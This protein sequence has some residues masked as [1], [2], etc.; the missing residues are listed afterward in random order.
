MLF[1]SDKAG[2]KGIERLKQEI[3]NDTELS[4]R[5]KLIYP[6]PPKLGK[7]YNE[8]L[9]IHVKAARTAQRQRDGAR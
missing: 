4:G 2:L 6:N 3:Q 9:C 1:R 8:F 7:D 5:V